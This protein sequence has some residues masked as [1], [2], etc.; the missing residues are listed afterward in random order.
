V[1]YKWRVFSNWN[2]RFNLACFVLF[3]A[4]YQRR[5][6]LAGPGITVVMLNLGIECVRVPVEYN[7]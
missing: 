1:K 6:E 4:C 2:F 5:G 3:S 7:L